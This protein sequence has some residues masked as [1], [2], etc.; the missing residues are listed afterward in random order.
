MLRVDTAPESWESEEEGIQ[1]REQTRVGVMT[2]AEIRQGISG[3][4]HGGGGE[5][6]GCGAVLGRAD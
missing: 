6:R 1:R 3:Q 4:G 2:S 5:K